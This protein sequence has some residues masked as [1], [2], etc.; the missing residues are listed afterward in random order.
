M[1]LTKFGS[2]AKRRL[3]LGLLAASAAVLFTAVNFVASAFVGE[4][5]MFAESIS[6][7]IWPL[8][9]SSFFSILA[10]CMAELAAH[11]SA[12]KAGHPR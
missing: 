12:P 4:K 5:Q 7:S 8:C 6:K 3:A 10:L 2:I 11:P 1:A 9:F